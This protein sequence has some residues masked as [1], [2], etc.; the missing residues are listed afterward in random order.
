MCDGDYFC[1]CGEVSAVN[2]YNIMAIGLGS[3]LG[4]AGKVGGGLY[5]AI[6]GRKLFDAYKRQQENL[7]KDMRQKNDLWY[8]R[9]YNELGTE[10]ADAQAA[11]TAMRDAQAQRMANMAGRSAVMG[12]STA[13]RAAEQNAQNQAI[14]KVAQN[15]NA[16]SE[17]RKETIE[18][19]YRTQDN[20]IDNKQ[21]ALNKEL[22]EHQSGQIQKAGTT[23]GELA[24]GM[25]GALND[26]D[27]R[28][29]WNK[30]YRTGGLWQ[31]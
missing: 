3:I 31:G 26:T 18:N 21:S 25:S 14:G 12:G 23:M 9:R 22:Y 4:L 27:V 29:I 20:A 7:L 24:D 2:N 15:I 16:D 5:S 8:N 11:L 13:L 10:R 1:S 19:R 30:K 28:G 6:K 17:S